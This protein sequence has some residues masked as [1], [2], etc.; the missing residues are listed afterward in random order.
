MI[1]GPTRRAMA[2]AAFWACAAPGV[3]LGGSAPFRPYRR[4]TPETALDAHDGT[5][6]RWRA[7]VVGGRRRG[8]VAFIYLGCASQCPPVLATLQALDARASPD[9]DLYTL[10][11]SP[12]SDDVRLMGRQA[13]DMGA[14]PRWRWLTG[15]PGVVHALLDALD[16]SYADLGTHE[17]TLFRVGR[18]NCDRLDGLPGADDLIEALK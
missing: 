14:S 11:L 4:P 1:V 9:I 7:D 12:L 2:F 16:V 10:T 8:V 18:G 15:E 3:A 6:L 17:Q 13:R 5:R